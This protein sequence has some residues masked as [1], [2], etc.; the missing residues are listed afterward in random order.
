MLPHPR[1]TTRL[2]QY[3]LSIGIAASCP[4]WADEPASFVGLGGLH[5]VP[6]T[7]AVISAATGVSSDGGTIV[8]TSVDSQGRT[9][10]F[11][12]RLSTGM[13]PLADLASGAPAGYH[14]TGG[15]SANGHVITGTVWS[16]ASCPTA[17]SWTELSAPLLLGDRACS[18]AFFAV[19][20][21][22][23]LLVGDVYTPAA[24]IAVSWSV[25]G[26][27]HVLLTTPATY[28]EATARGISDDGAFIVGSC[29]GTPGSQALVWENGNITPRG[30][31]HL[32][33]AELNQTSRAT[34]ISP[35]GTHIV[36][37]SVSGVVRGDGVTRGFIYPMPSGPMTSLGDPGGGRLTSP[38]DVCNRGEVVVG[39]VY[40]RT[41]P[42]SETAF[43]WTRAGGFQELKSHLE[44][45]HGL[46]L[47]GWHLTA[48]SGISADGSV[49]VGTGTSPSGTEA[50]R[51]TI[52]AIPEPCVA[53]FNRDGGVDGGDVASFYLAWI[54]SDPSADTNQDGGVDGSDVETFFVPWEAG[55]CD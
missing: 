23:T 33:N 49:I 34:A 9:R 46:N 25:I 43:I 4:A 7:G 55:G 1:C 2:F 36:G 22:G 45:T 28:R 47:S 5:T 53:D 10:P 30:L 3:V 20:G 19:S 13:E 38:R 31:G 39:S 27:S 35:D 48:A 21:D 52:P 14:D 17:A 29:F 11:R 32:P 15:A 24:S 42:F 18:S 8:G 44:T 54:D 50:W 40:A 37:E 41:F 51:A 12:W 16:P 26:E 6:E